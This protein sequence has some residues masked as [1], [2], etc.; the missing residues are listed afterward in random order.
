MTKIPMTPTPAVSPFIGLNAYLSSCRTKFAKCI[1]VVEHQQKIN[2]VAVTTRMQ[3]LKFD[4]NGK[5]M[6]EALAEC[7]Y[8]HIIDY[9][10]AAKYRTQPLTAHEA[11]RLTKEARKLFIHPPATA[12]DPDRTG[13]AGEILLYFLLEAILGAPQVVAKMELKTNTSFEVLGSDGIHMAWNAADSLVDMYFGESKIHQ[14]ISTAMSSAIKSI[15]SFHDEG[16]CRHEF[17]M[18]TKHFKYANVEIQAAV[19]DLIGEGVSS[20]GVR[21]NHACLIG[22]NWS[23]YENLPTFSLADLTSEFQKRYIADSERIHKLLQDRFSTFKHKH[24]RFEVFF[25]PFKTVQEFRDAFN[26]ALK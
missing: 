19:N 25:L 9:C 20:S 1:D 4:G 5:P 24:L 17:K 22:Y 13:E 2:S 18:V 12:A 7:L 10:L 26:E 14:S 8:A 3:Y 11:T 6:V 23:E 16:M 21:I 15:E